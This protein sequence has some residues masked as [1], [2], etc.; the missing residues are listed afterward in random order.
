VPD[1]RAVVEEFAVLGKKLIP[2]PGFQTL[3]F[4]VGS[5]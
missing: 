5:S 4:M 1:E 2:Q 3:P